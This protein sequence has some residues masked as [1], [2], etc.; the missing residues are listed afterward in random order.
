MHGNGATCVLWLGRAVV[1]SV[2][3]MWTVVL[4]IYLVTLGIRGMKGSHLALWWPWWTLAACL[5]AVWCKTVPLFEAE[6]CL[7]HDMCDGYGFNQITVCFSQLVHMGWQ[8][9]WVNCLRNTLT[10][11]TSFSCSSHSQKNKLKSLWLSTHAAHVNDQNVNIKSLKRNS[12]N[13]GNV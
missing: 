7:W 11:Q 8:W 13:K 1:I 2:M 3:N 9:V 4:L 6:G 5:H 10:Y 12:K